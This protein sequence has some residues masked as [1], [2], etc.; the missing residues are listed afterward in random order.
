MRECYRGKQN[1]NRPNPFYQNSDWSPSSCLSGIWLSGSIRNR[2]VWLWDQE[3]RR[4]RKA[5][6][7]TVLLREKRLLRVEDYA[8]GWSSLFTQLALA[9]TTREK[10]KNP[11]CF[12]DESDPPGAGRVQKPMAQMLKGTGCGHGSAPA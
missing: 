10:P 6:G 9:Q 7:M 5:E 12:P 8:F 2:G 11:F 4:D 3:E 1:P